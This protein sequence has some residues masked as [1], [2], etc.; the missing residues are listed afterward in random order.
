MISFYI[1]VFTQYLRLVVGMFL[2]IGLFGSILVM[3]CIAV[4]VSVQ[5]AIDEPNLK[6]LGIALFYVL[7]VSGLYWYILPMFWAPGF[8]A[9]DFRVRIVPYFEKAVSVKSSGRNHP[10][11]QGRKIAKNLRKLNRYATAA[12]ARPLSAFG[13]KDDKLG[14]KMKWH[15]PKQGL[16]TIDRILDR[17]AGQAGRSTI[18][19]GHADLIKELALVRE[20][21]QMASDADVRFAFVVRMAHE[22]DLGWSY[23]R[24]GCFT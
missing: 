21:L 24:I 3:G 19:H 4:I 16:L 11:F 12:G 5:W 8:K 23:E 7:F 20:W 18:R 15:D 2:V 10:F 9:D 14:Q 17:L 22:A 1:N 6:H 13:F